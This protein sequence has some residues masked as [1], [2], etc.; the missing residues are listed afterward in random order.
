MRLPKLNPKLSVKELTE[1]DKDL[2]KLSGQVDE[3]LT[4]LRREHQFAVTNMSVVELLK[5]PEIATEKLGCHSCAI[6]RLALLMFCERQ[7][8]Q[9]LESPLTQNEP[10]C[11]G[12]YDALRS[13]ADMIFKSSL[14]QEAVAP[15]AP[16]NRKK[17]KRAV[18]A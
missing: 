13:Y 5:M 11:T 9:R 4:K 2:S 16:G 1:L 10:W 17:R 7:S 6:M 12:D 18:A 8:I 3:A 14:T 15:L